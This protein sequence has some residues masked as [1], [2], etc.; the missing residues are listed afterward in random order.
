M[1]VV[2][3]Y[4]H[5]RDHGRLKGGAT[6]RVVGD[7]NSD[8]VSVQFTLCSNKDNFSRQIGRGQAMM[9]LKHRILLSELPEFLGKIHEHAFVTGLTCTIPESVDYS[10]ATKYFTPKAA[11]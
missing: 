4:F 10:Y 8:K 11:S 9:K 7:T 6:V 1:S 2:E 3:R 5:I